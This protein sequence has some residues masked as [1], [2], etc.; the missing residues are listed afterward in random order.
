VCLVPL[1]RVIGV[2]LVLE[3]PYAGDDIGANGA[4]DK[5]LDV[6]GDQ[7]NKFFF[8]GVTTVQIDKGSMD[9]GGHW[10]QGRC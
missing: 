4:R 3:E 7:G 6:D 9:R 1:Q 5:I 8:Q 2:E 10:Q